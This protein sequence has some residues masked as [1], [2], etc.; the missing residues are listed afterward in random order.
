MD[1]RETISLHLDRFELYF[2]P[3]ENEMSPAIVMRALF[4]TLA[5]A[6]MVAFSQATFAKTYV[7]KLTGRDTPIQLP[8]DWKTGTIPNGVEFKSGDDEVYMWIQAVTNST[9]NA[10]I[11]EYFSYYKKQ[12]VTFGQPID[13]STDQIAGVSVSL[14][15]IPATFEGGPTI[16]KFVISDSKDGAN[17]GM[18]IGYWASPKGHKVH[19]AAVVKILEDLLRP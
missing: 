6:A 5:L 12:G 9:V 14:L 8:N 17:K 11:D 2:R 13:K 4:I 3:L 7:F 10:A 18:L 15:N 16:I 1:L 19:D